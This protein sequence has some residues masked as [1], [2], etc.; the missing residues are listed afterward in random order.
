[1]EAMRSMQLVSKEIGC[2][3]RGVAEHSRG[4]AQ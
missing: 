3:G 4:A 1:M 2:K